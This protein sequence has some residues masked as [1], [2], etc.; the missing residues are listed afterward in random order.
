MSQ[1]P[2]ATGGL[3]AAVWSSRASKPL[4]KAAVE[5]RAE[6]RLSLAEL[7]QQD[8]ME[9][10]RR[11][12]ASYDNRGPV[13]R[14]LDMIDLP[15]NVIASTLA[16]ELQRKAKEAGETGALGIGRVS[17]SDML[18]AAGV[19]NRV[20]RGVLGF[21]GDVALDPLTY[22]GPAGWGV[23]ATATAGKASTGVRGAAK[24]TEV[25]G[26]LKRAERAAESTGRAIGTV[27]FRKE[28][29]KAVTQAG[30]SIQSSKPIADDALRTYFDAWKKWK[31]DADVGEAFTGAKSSGRAARGLSWIGGDLDF[32]GGD[33]ARLIYTAPDDLDDAGKAAREA[34]KAVVLKYGKGTEAGITIGKGGVKVRGAG[35]TAAQAEN[36]AETM[37][38]AHIPGTSIS[39]NI[40]AWTVASRNA[41]MNLSLAGR[42]ATQ[43]SN[44][45]NIIDAMPITTD[46]REVLGV[47][48]LGPD[49]A[50]W[51]KAAK[52]TGNREPGRFRTSNYAVGEEV[53]ITVG[54]KERRP[55]QWAKSVDA[56]K[57][58]RTVIREIYYPGELEHSI[59]KTT[60]PEILVEVDGSDDLYSLQELSRVRVADDK[61]TLP[62]TG[63]A[64]VEAVSRITRDALPEV[65]PSNIQDAFDNAVERAR[66]VAG[67]SRAAITKAESDLDEAF[68]VMTAA[69][70]NV[71]SSVKPLS[72]KDLNA[73]AAKAVKY[74][75]PIPKSAQWRR[76]VGRDIEA[77]I[78]EPG[79]ADEIAEPLLEMERVTGVAEAPRYSP[80]PETFINAL[81]YAERKVTG[82]QMMTM[83][84]GDLRVGDTFFVGETRGVVRKRLKDKIEVEFYGNLPAKA[85]D[86]EWSR[87]V[88]ESSVKQVF[89]ANQEIV[90]SRGGLARLDIDF[91]TR[92]VAGVK[93]MPTRDVV[94]D[95]RKAMQELRV[96]RRK[97]QI[98]LANATEYAS[99]VRDQI[100]DML[101]RAAAIDGLSPEDLLSIRTKID[102]MN[103]MVLAANANRR[104]AE[105]GTSMANRMDD[106]LLVAKEQAAE[107]I[108]FVDAD[109]GLGASLQQIYADAFGAA[110]ALSTIYKAPVMSLVDQGTSG[111]VEIAK[112]VLATND[113]MQGLGGIAGMAKAVS[114]ATGM[115]FP[116]LQE[117][118]NLLMSH[119]ATIFGRR[120]GLTEAPL[121]AIAFLARGG[122]KRVAVFVEG[123]LDK[124]N[125]AMQAAGVETSR[126]S[127]VS[128]MLTSVIYSR[129][130]ETGRGSVYWTK[131]EFR[132]LSLAEL[133]ALKVR[134]PAEYE[135]A[136]TNMTKALINAEE[137]GLLTNQAL[138]EA[139]T[140]IADDAIKQIDDLR[141]AG[142]ADGLLSLGLDNYGL[143]AVAPPEAER[144]AR[145]MQSTET[146]KT[147]TQESGPSFARTRGTQQYRYL[148][149]DGTPRAFLEMHR[150]LM[151][152][153]DDDIRKLVTVSG[154][155][156]DARRERLIDARD[157]AIEYFNR[158]AA[159]EQMPVP[160][161]TDPF[162]VNLPESEGGIRESIEAAYGGFAGPL[163]ETDPI[164]MIASRVHSHEMAIGKKT[165]LLMVGQNSYFGVD[166]NAL[167]E[168]VNKPGAVAT[169][170]DGRTVKP[171]YFR[172]QGGGQ[173]VGF[174]VGD[175]A[176]RQLD[177]A[178][179]TSQNQLFRELF[180][181][182]L[183]D[184]AVPSVLA[185]RVEGIMEALTKNESDIW[186]GIEAV[187]S[188]WKTVTL[189]SPSYIVN[190][191]IGN[192]LLLAGGDPAGGRYNLPSITK[193]LP[194]II[195]FFRDKSMGR[196][197]D[198]TIEVGGQQIRLESIFEDA[199]RERLIDSSFTSSNT[200]PSIYE[201]T[202]YAGKFDV[203]AAEIAKRR[204]AKEATLGDKFQ[205]ATGMF[206]DRIRR[207]VIH[208]F[209]NMATGVDNAYKL[210]AFI[211]K[212]QQGDSV[213]MAA[214][215]VERTLFDYSNLT[216][217]EAKFRVLMPFYSWIRNNTG[218]QVKN[219]LRRP[220]YAAAFPK[221]KEAL[222]EFSAGEEKLPEAARPRWMRESLA[223]QFGSDP[224]TRSAFLA[225]SR[226]PVEQLYRL[227]A[228]TQGQQG[229]LD[230]ANYIGSMVNPFAGASASLAFGRELF[231]GR[232]IGPDGDRSIPEY[233]GSLFR[234]L[235][236]VQR[237][238][239]SLAEGKPIQALSRVFLGGGVQDMS[240]DR[241]RAQ[242][243]RDY[244]DKVERLRRKIRR[245]ER[246]GNA[247]VSQE[248]RAELLQVYRAMIQGGLGD[249]V[250][251]WAIEQIKILENAPP[252][253]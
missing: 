173:A 25:A 205:A 146:S 184:A 33:L 134:S 113:V 179:Q 64:T 222:E 193:N 136:A 111:A 115:D 110:L 105:I 12:L 161:Q 52:P 26:T 125:K 35:R 114:A 101:G 197:I 191:G 103:A 163:R 36:A 159:G 109:P 150:D 226:L 166:F 149:A 195:K 90:F 82:D 187:T 139:L 171:M 147:F 165:F 78:K 220:A 79:A 248:A 208:P 172:T 175:T 42:K 196:A 57:P 77:I 188:A 92:T 228:I 123:T 169:L 189:L 127:E 217:L 34:A 108:K 72:A 210:A 87:A 47:G 160:K 91:P 106:P 23:R 48:G 138:K 73:R 200:A 40:P 218:Y 167:R 238:G 69:E 252:E 71:P 102:E 186:K 234:P 22:I 157:N 211:D 80:E 1:L 61:P 239:G 5:Q 213:Q 63:S 132:D 32:Q 51:A 233:L 198:E 60:N 81:A 4:D 182:D 120:N 180:G 253:T 144:A 75:G 243:L 174:M 30:R 94:D 177:P 59:Y 18:G 84:S 245:N 89:D 20:V 55:G 143:P 112:S 225:G 126:I 251:K 219:F 212:L 11:A 121:K 83:R 237:I 137:S 240:D 88:K 53:D 50:E 236:E 95:L 104:L 65:K 93:V 74:P 67:E 185:D 54:A 133:K 14:V 151:G 181:V 176:Y 7:N 119:E 249:E 37:A 24:F 241:V 85:G 168:V 155:V 45:A 107:I 44:V 100:E 135:E 250:P 231:S 214:R 46:V 13:Q 56:D 70:K 66:S 142:Q 140:G 6:P 15:R 223:I 96:L 209:F 98:E 221:T 153:S 192:N 215:A 99:R 246:G 206:A 41:R 141:V 156:D 38:I 199:V 216:N 86:G 130:D 124:M 21:A 164:A 68:A 178:V 162:S 145:K 202:R 131:P 49:S 203:V 3:D 152:L 39:L 128:A 29:G 58:T 31:P 232:E 10:Q 16:P 62:K 27:E 201:N 17:V 9:L 183:G 117:Q 230:T 190:N 122:D 242:V 158:A 148:S 227:L 207:T 170:K 19:E 43:T 154:R 97:R 229:I 235:N 28:F 204:G 8:L 129:L 194:T 244:T 224:E 2:N 76:P 247:A 116:S 118:L